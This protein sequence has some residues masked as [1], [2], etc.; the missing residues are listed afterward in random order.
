[1]FIKGREALELYVNLDWKTLLDECKSGRVLP[2]RRRGSPDDIFTDGADFFW[3][4][5]KTPDGW[6]RVVTLYEKH[7]Y[8]SL[9]HKYSRLKA[10]IRNAD[11]TEAERI[12]PYK[13]NLD[14]TVGGGPPHKSPGIEWIIEHIPEIERCEVSEILA[15]I[16]SL[17]K[18][19]EPGR[20]WGDPR[21]V[22]SEVL[23]LFIKSS[24]IK[25]ELERIVCPPTGNS[26]L[27][28]PVPWWNDM[29][30][31]ARR[32][33]VKN[34]STNLSHLFDDQEEITVATAAASSLEPADEIPTISFYLNG[35]YWLIGKPNQEKPVP[36]S[37]GMKRIQY[38]IENGKGKGLKVS[39]LPSDDPIKRTERTSAKKTCDRALE[40]ILK[41]D[42]LEF[43]AEYLNKGTLHIGT[44]CWYKPAQEKPVDWNFNSPK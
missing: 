13:N 28:D 12:E 43:L 42:G 30:N 10:L 8:A 16:E 27:P 41:T 14:S 23:E 19:L 40:T 24:F 20:M 7:T 18:E 15:E 6:L 31:E 1:M 35:K 26:T 37:I 5:A 2:L 33:R 4:D 29:L 11:L 34:E 22:F 25:E 21:L 36:D 32:E 38:V 44:R 17:E 9:C 3:Y 39:G